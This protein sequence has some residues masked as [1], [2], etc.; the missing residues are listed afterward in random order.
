MADRHV[1]HVEVLL[2]LARVERVTAGYI[3]GE[4]GAVPAHGCQPRVVFAESEPGYL[5]P[6]R[7]RQSAQCAGAGVKLEHMARPIAKRDQRTA[8]VFGPCRNLRKFWQCDVF[9]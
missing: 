2:H 7:R 1:A 8:A 3:E 4:R 5:L 9:G 6:K